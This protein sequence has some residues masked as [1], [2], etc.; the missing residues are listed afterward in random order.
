MSDTRI[1]DTIIEGADLEAEAAMVK[2]LGELGKGW[3]EK[4]GQI[5]GFASVEELLRAVAAGTS[6]DNVTEAFDLL[7][8]SDVLSFLQGKGAR[9]TELL[10]KVPDEVKILLEPIGKYDDTGDGT[11]NPGLVE[12]P[13]I[14]E[15]T[16]G[17]GSLGGDDS[18]SF[19]FGGKAALS[20]EAGEKWRYS[21]AVPAPLIRMR[22]EGAVNA[23]AGAKLPF[24]AGSVAVDAEA[25]AACRLEYYYLVDDPKAIYAVAVGQRLAKVPNPFDLDGVWEAFRTSDL[26]ALHYAFEGSASMSVAL[27]V[28]KTF[29]SAGVGDF[30]L[31]ASIRAGF[32]LSGHWFLSLRRDPSSSAADPRIIVTLSRQRSTTADLLA[33]LGVDVDLTELAQRV[34]GIL[35][36]LLDDWDAILGEVKPYLSPG[37][38]LQDKA[39][40]LIA[41]KAKE[42]VDDDDLRAAL[43]RDLEGVIGVGTPGK[44]ALQEWL[45][46]KLAGAV[47][48]AEGW[49]GD[50]AKGVATSAAALGS[51]LPA[52]AESRFREKIDSA[53]GDLI[54][55][56]ADKLRDKVGSLVDGQSE[57]LEKALAKAGSKVSGA[58]SDV[59]NAF[60]AVRDLVDRYDRIFREIVDATADASR[61]KISAGVQI[62]ESRTNRTTVEIE[63]TFLRLSDASRD[64]FKSIVKGDLGAL[65][66][67]FDRGDTADFD[68]NEE[69][70]SV[71]RYSASK[72]GV[73]FDLVLLGFGISGGSLLESEASV[74]VDGNGNVQVDAKAK[75][76]KFFTGWGEERRIELVSSF[77][78]TWAR[79]HQNAP[80]AIDRALG[81]SVTLGHIDKELSRKHVKRFVA[82]LV[83]E[84]LVAS[85]ALATADETFT[86]WA[87]S[88]GS[89]AKIDGRIQLKLALDKAA[90]GRMLDLGTGSTAAAISHSRRNDIILRG[91]KTLYENDE[92]T[93]ELVANAFRVLKE[94]IRNGTEREFVLDLRRSER[95]LVD[96]TRRQIGRPVYYLG[97]DEFLD[98]GRLAHRMVE[99]IETLREIY[100]S[101]P[102]TKEDNSP[103]TWSADDYKDAE[104]RAARAASGWLRLNASFFLENADVHP[105]TLAFFE[106]MAWM[107]GID[108][109]RKISLVIT[110]NTSDGPET[111]VLQG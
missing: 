76:E 10:D 67:L 26:A 23:E 45:K 64:I 37:T 30:D 96:D 28:A 1:L 41:D 107:A 33:K 34:H 60:A 61:A 101:V 68:L 42:L 94:K 65:V 104:K 3:I 52:L 58:V 72:T 84:N 35:K 103:A 100:F 51:S 57:A 73:R 77:A 54:S 85:D 83:D 50:Q 38:L 102:E 15:S 4:A 87:G 74:L 69:R 82:S 12:W 106:M 14:D 21:D 22:A 62:E 47:D 110:C 8:A 5:D 46:G 11:A 98:F 88:P 93:A 39:K 2:A 49:A 6:D 92:E 31:G 70:S 13:I 108:P 99:L 55:D 16:G 40:G 89:K 48:A 78:L 80:A 25:S 19:S 29:S 53:L 43:V 75:L 56:A 91:F 79:A 105:R 63:G 71:L 59:D 109:K 32:A 86:R 44:P 24:S 81:L 20:L 7:G 111:L 95:K 27:A 9:V 36:D 90:L 66:E 17:S 18:Y 97:G